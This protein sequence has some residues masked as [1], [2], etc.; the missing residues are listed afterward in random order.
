MDSYKYDI[1]ISL[2]QQDMDFAKR[3]VKAINPSVKVFFYEDRQDQLISKSG[4]EAFSKTFK[5]ES[6]VVV[7]LSRNEWSNSFYTEIERNAI[8]DRTAV[9]NEGYHFLMVIPMVQG[10]IP[11][12]YPSTQI[13]AS[14]F[15][16]TVEEI[17]HFIEFKVTEEG[18]IVKALT[19]EERYQN[20]IDR[21]EQKR[22]IVSLQHEKIAVQRAKEEMAIFKDCFNSKG[23][24]FQKNVIDK[25]F[26]KEF[27]PFSNRSCFGYGDYVLE[28]RFL[29]QDEFY[30]QITTTQ[31]LAIRF[32]LLKIS[33]AEGEN[34]TIDAEDRVFYYTPELQ[35][36]GLPN[37]C[38]HPTN[39]EI[40][41]LFRDKS[42]SQFY[43]LTNPLGADVLV[44]NWFQKLL[45]KST[46]SIER[47]L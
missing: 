35:G 27:G 19:V 12:W 26:S 6:R 38:E 25:F 17:A 47:Y 29:F 36:W 37:I 4:P 16:F 21:V 34:K 40:Q 43:N 20:Y 39:K 33:S 13:Y 45:S 9:R 3:L 14:P 2:C 42:K 5:E 10:E 24:F 23:R 46:E 18:G 44:D 1:A 28:C 15:R 22:S 30:S 31:D 7:I 11:A 8:V 32:E 41:V